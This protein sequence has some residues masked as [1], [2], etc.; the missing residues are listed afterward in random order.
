MFYIYHY[1]FSDWGCNQNKEYIKLDAPLENIIPK[2]RLIAPNVRDHTGNKIEITV[3]ESYSGEGE[4]AISGIESQN[5]TYKL[6]NQYVVE[7]NKYIYV[8]AS[9]NWGGS[10]TFYYMTAV[11]KTTLKSVDEIFLGD[12]IK[13]NAFKLTSTWSDAVSLTY[14]IRSSSVPM[15]APRNK[16]VEIHYKMSQSKLIK[17]IK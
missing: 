13:V 7:G 9:Y 16:K 1:W 11:D 12:R 3:G 8:I 14:M 2:I 6:H 4:Y 10:G 17:Y 5:F 15:A